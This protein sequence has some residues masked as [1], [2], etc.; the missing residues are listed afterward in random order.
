MPKPARYKRALPDP[1]KD[2]FAVAN[3]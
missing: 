3:L 1:P 2:G